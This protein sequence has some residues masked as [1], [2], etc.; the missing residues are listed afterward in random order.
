MRTAYCVL[1]VAL[2]APLTVAGCREQPAASAKDYTVKGKV[3]AVDAS[4]P[5][6]T[7]DHEEIP[8][9]MKAMQMEYSAENAKMLEG[10]KVGDQVEGHLKVQ[11]G[12][13]VITHLEKR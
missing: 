4:K 10:I 3:I 8:G 1:I 12:A 6:V 9:L 5:V 7:L 2:L 13:Y 11:D